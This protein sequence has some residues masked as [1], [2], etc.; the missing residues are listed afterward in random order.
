ML[1]ERFKRLIVKALPWPIRLVIYAN[2]FPKLKCHHSVE[3][4]IDG[5]FSFGKN[6]VI[7]KDSNIKVESDSRLHFE[8]KVYIGR[9]VEIGA[10]DILIGY[11]TSIQDRCVLLGNINIGVGVIFGPNVYV[12][13]GGHHFNIAPHLSIR[14][15]DKIGLKSLPYRPVIIEDDC[16]IG[17]NSVILPGV[18]IGKG[19][20]IGANSVVTKD[21]PPY[22]VCVGAP[23]KVI[24]KRLDFFPPKTLN[25]SAEKDAPYFYFGFQIINGK[26]TVA[27]SRF[28][29]CVDTSD[30]KTLEIECISNISLYITCES[31]LRHIDAGSSKIVFELAKNSS[32][33]VFAISDYSDNLY[34]EII[35]VKAY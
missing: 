11:D 13:S 10:V 20:V 29:I 23:A 5:L 34:F 7:S 24:K 9:N 22:S 2:R 12:T 26:V 31:Q 18:K 28:G 15:Q 19:S 35:S 21:I 1:L 16:W 33:I 25:A 30:A 3:F 8:N 4:D 17:V 6:C 32:P 27:G 14:E